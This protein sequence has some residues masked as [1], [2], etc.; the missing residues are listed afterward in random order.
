MIAGSADMLQAL[1]TVVAFGITTLLFATA[2]RILPRVRIAWSDVWMGAVVTA[3]LFTLGKVPHRPLHRPSRRELQFRR[4]R[5]AHH[6]APVGLL[7]RRRSSCLAR[8]SPGCSRTVSGSRV[9]VPPVERRHPAPVSARSRCRRCDL[10]RSATQTRLPGACAQARLLGTAADYGHHQRRLAVGMRDRR[11]SPR[12]ARRAPC[13]T[14]GRP[15]HSP[16]PAS[17]P[18]ASPAR[19]DAVAMSVPPRRHPTRAKRVPRRSIDSHRVA[20]YFRSVAM[21]EIG[22]HWRDAAEQSRRWTHGVAP[23]IRRGVWHVGSLNQVASLLDSTRAYLSPSALLLDAL[24]AEPGQDRQSSA[25]R[26]L[27]D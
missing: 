27:V 1:N 3:I 25:R 13:A 4:R 20:M 24:E 26:D 11:T 18:P 16:A 17:V 23:C 9:G 12:R 8:S 7:L 15:P 21:R 2:Y 22:S 14:S 5:I 19:S 10:W 6:R